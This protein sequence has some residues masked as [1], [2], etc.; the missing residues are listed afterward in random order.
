[1]F[2]ALDPPWNNHNKF[3]KIARPP[4]S[5]QLHS[6]NKNI[7]LPL[8]ECFHALAKAKFQSVKKYCTVMPRWQPSA[9][10]K[11]QGSKKL[12]WSSFIDSYWID[13]GELVQSF[14]REKMCLERSQSRPGQSCAGSQSARRRYRQKAQTSSW[15]R[16]HLQT[17][18]PRGHHHPVGSIANSRL[19]LG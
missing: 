8:P 17:W 9:A 3:A 6:K 2:E 10:E 5:T 18:L 15:R 14:R 4:F 16:P 1:M 7:D 13:D 19:Y 12:F 11:S